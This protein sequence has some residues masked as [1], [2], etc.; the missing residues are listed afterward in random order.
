MK[1][2]CHCHTI[3]SDGTLTPK[4]LLDLA[5]TQQLTGLSITDHDTLAA[6]PEALSYAKTLDIEL[7]SGI[8][9]S[10]E[11][12]KKSIHVLG[13]AFN[14][15][16]SE[17]HNFCLALQ[18]NR[19]QRNQAMCARLTKLGVPI[20]IGEL[21]A[22]FSIGS[23]GRPH[24]AQ[25][26]VE[27]GFVR[28]FKEAFDRYIGDHCGGYIPGFQVEVPKAIDLIQQ[29]GGFAVLAHPYSISSKKIVSELKEMP[30][31]GVEVYY[32]HTTPLQIMPW[33][34]ITKNKGWIATGGSDFHDM[35]ISPPLGCAWT[36]PE[37]F[38]MLQERYRQNNP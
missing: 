6:Y 14:L 38:L 24:I 36:P 18:H 4:A 34:E 2:D 23:I 19:E 26:M 27:K 10:A 30:F 16:N 32:R 5:K 20:D 17:L 35:A 37:Y 8:E 25:L 3:H 22:R 33:L 28:S 31:D 13:Y 7:I 21:H 9:I 15:Q 12:Q 11:H 1:A 29:A